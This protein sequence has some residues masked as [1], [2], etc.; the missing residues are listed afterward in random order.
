MEKKRRKRGP[1]VYMVF[2]YK[3]KDEYEIHCD[4]HRRDGEANSHKRAP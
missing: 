3:Q 1:I 2:A 4:A